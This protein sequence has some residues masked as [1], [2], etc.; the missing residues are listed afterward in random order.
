MKSRY[1][2]ATY[3]PGWSRMTAVRG[4]AV[5]ACLAISASPLAAQGNASWSGCRTDSLSTY[6]CAHYY[7]GTVSFRSVLKGATLNQTRT[8]VATVTGGQVSCKITDTEQG[9]YSGPGMIAVEHGSTTNAGDYEISVWCPEAEGERPTRNDSP[10]F[11]VMDQKAADYSA[12]EG[13]EEYESANADEANG[14]TG[15]DSVTWN[16]R[17]R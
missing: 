7:S 5:L 14:V 4:A 13:K 10:M 15:T 17:R 11:Q 9:D 2:I 16:L 1:F 6:N 12:L 3:H 8:V